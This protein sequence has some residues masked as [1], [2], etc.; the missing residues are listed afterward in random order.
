MPPEL[1]KELLDDRTTVLRLRV[2]KYHRMID[3]GFFADAEPFELLD[4]ILVRKDR[5]AAG[6]DP[7]TI[8]NHH[9]WAVK[10][11]AKLSRKLERFGCHMQTQQPVALPPFNE[12][13]PDGAIV[14]GVEDDYE[15]RPPGAADVT[16]IIEV[17][18]ASLRRDRT[19]K[20]QIYA[21]A[22]IGQ[23]VIVNLPDRMVEVYSKPLPR[24]RRYDERVILPVGRKV[25]LAAARGKRLAVAVETL[26]PSS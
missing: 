4:G 2:E 16:C 1:L 19:A 5:S 17:S 11:L 20:L 22:G 14:L 10:K 13:E 12:P 3:A 9:A 21:G 6:A 8:S 25:E 18:D 15:D 24:K 23:Y 7:M 26:L